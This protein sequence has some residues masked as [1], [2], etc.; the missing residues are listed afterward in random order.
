MDAPPEADGPGRQLEQVRLDLCG[1]ALLAGCCQELD[2][3]PGVLWDRR[4]RA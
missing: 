2:D 3:V 4:R 1:Q